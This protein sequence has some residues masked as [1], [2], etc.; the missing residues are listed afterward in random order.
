MRS[1][2][3][4][5][6]KLWVSVLVFLGYFALTMTFQYG[7]T[8]L[9]IPVLA[10]GF[11]PIGEGLDRRFGWYRQV[12]SFG[13]LVFI[14]SI[15]IIIQVYDLLDAVVSV[16]IFA[17]IYSLIHTKRE[18]NYGHILLLSFFLVLAASVLSP[19]AGI[20]L[21][22][23]LF[24]G[25]GVG[26]LSLLEMFSSQRPAEGQGLGSVRLEDASGRRAASEQGR[27]FDFRTVPVVI[28]AALVVLVLTPMLF[29]VIPRTEAGFLGTSQT[30]P[31]VTTGIAPEVDLTLAGFLSG[32][33]APVMRVEFPEEPGGRYDAPKLW[34]STALDSY[35]GT[36]WKRRGLITQGV[37]RSSLSLARFKS[38]R[39]LATRE[40]LIR[41]SFQ[42]GREVYHEI[43][44]DRAPVAGIP[45]LQMVRTIVAGDVN[46]RLQF[47]WGDEGDFS[48]NI[49][50]SLEKGIALRVWSEVP[51]LDPEILRGSS[52]DYR[53]VMVPS[54]LRNLTYHNL[55]PR[56]LK[57]VEDLTKEAPTVYDKV[58]AV[59]DWLRYSGEFVYSKDIPLLTLQNPVDAFILQAKTGHCELYASALALMVR[60]LGIPARVVS[61]YR[62]GLWDE[63]DRSYTV[64]NDMAHLWTEVYF[65][66]AGW[67]PFDPSP[68]QEDPALFSLDTLA[69]SYSR[70][71]LKAKLL[72]L[73][74]VV[75]F[76]PDSESLFFRDTMF[77]AVRSIGGFAVAFSA[78]ELQG[79]LLSRLRAPILAAV[80]LVGT[81]LAV[82]IVL[83]RTKRRRP[84]APG[85]LT[86]DQRRALKLHGRVTRRLRRFGFDCRGMTTEEIGEEIPRLGLSDPASAVEVLAEYS[87]S[88]FG[89]RE[90]S[91]ARCKDLC[92]LVRGLK[93]VAQ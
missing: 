45:A 69:R 79:T 73:S 71:V 23:L 17:Q 65:P 66:D 28:L 42:L 84:G 2:V 4:R 33:A 49:G 77:R 20:G 11:M 82:L 92:R 10:V 18:R 3:E 13:I 14:L 47:R 7:Q 21:V 72:W 38:D 53:A 8:L 93:V 37:V 87:A 75:S 5:R 55:L 85:V 83:R 88:R 54:D 81:A 12:T 15:P 16:V 70:Y 36:S 51:D 29:I 40:G 32:N 76:S 57:V 58:M 56:T 63:N 9:L 22:Y 25:F 30:S 31:Q 64:T 60:S 41:P 91:A 50:G 86:P 27:S 48:V 39:R 46:R 52:T 6:L 78:P 35:T 80:V 90:L 44:M 34:R 61:G 74:N 19:Q 89:R 24:V 62:G 43:F 1:G 67:I 26:A 68:P 59:H